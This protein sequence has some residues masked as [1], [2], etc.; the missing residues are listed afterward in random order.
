MSPGSVDEPWTIQRAHTF[1]LIIE[2]RIY[3]SDAHEDE[4]RPRNRENGFACSRSASLTRR[5]RA[6]APTLARINDRFVFLVLAIFAVEG[7]ARSP[8]L[9]ADNGQ[10][11]IS[12]WR[13]W[14]WC[15]YKRGKFDEWIYYW[16]EFLFFLFLWFSWYRYWNWRGWILKR[17]ICETCF[18]YA[19]SF[20]LLILL[21]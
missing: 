4:S 13:W 8:N 15:E 6:V 16:I 21:F 9:R 14:W 19:Q 5:W 11:I 12:I 18:L 1:P 2:A 20:E 10:W 3:S 17:R 7:I